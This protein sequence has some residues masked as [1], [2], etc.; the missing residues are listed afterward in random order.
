MSLTLACTVNGIPGDGTTQG[1][2]NTGM[3]CHAN[4]T[5]T[6]PCR[7]NGI[8]GDGTTRGTCNQDQLCKADGTCTGSTYIKDFHAIS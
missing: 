1:T 4:G 7:V 3:L 2:C 6:L 8:P 5:C